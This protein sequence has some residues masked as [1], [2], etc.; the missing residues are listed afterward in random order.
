VIL[1]RAFAP[2][3]PSGLPR[4]LPSSL[5]EDETLCSTR[6]AFHR[7]GTL[8]RIR[9]S[10]AFSFAFTCAS[11]TTRPSVPIRTRVPELC[12]RAAQDYRALD[13]RPHPIPRLALFTRDE[14]RC[15]SGSGYRPTTSATDFR[16]TDTLTSSRFSHLARP[17]YFAVTFEDAFVV[18]MPVWTGGL[19]LS[20]KDHERCEP[21]QPFR[22]RPYDAASAPQDETSKANLRS[23]RRLRATPRSDHRLRRWPLDESAGLRGPSNPER[24]TIFHAAC[25]RRT[26]RAKVPLL[27]RA[28]R[29]S[30]GCRRFFA[31]RAG[32]SRRPH[33]P[34][35][36]IIPASPREEQ[37][38]PKSRDAFHPQESRWT[39]ITLRV[40]LNRYLPLRRRPTFVGVT[41][42]PEVPTPLFSPRNA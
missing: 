26:T 27:M 18:A 30:L 15:F 10:C 38:V 33:E 32:Y 34:T 6:G 17:A 11:A 4:S 35:E 7:W 40:H 42:Q 2:R 14:A 23:G 29:A 13:P 8:T 37:R 1:R 41:L 16:R 3:R 12:F 21:R 9:E 20:K 39:K 24:R 25:C 28:T 31:L 19:P 22:G 36:A 5:R